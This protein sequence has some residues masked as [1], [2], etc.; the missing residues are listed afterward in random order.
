MN[1]KY[2]ISDNKKFVILVLFTKNNHLQSIFLWY[3]LR[4]FIIFLMRIA[5]YTIINF[6]SFILLN[7]CISRSILKYKNL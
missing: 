1:L 5:N 3:Y 2:N 6:S 4:N 7:R